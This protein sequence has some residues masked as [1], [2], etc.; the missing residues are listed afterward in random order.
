[1]A[2]YEQ[3]INQDLSKPSYQKL[4]TM[5]K[6]YINQKIRTRNFQVRSER[7]ET[8]EKVKTQKGEECQR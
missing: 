1:M 7:I 8:G 4:K 2:M 6:R 3:E 5:I